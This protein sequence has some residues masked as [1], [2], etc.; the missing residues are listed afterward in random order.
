MA[1]FSKQW[2]DNNDS[3]IEPDFDIVEIWSELPVNFMNSVIC[4]GYGFVAIAKFE[5]YNE[6]IL[7]YNSDIV[8][9]LN[10]FEIVEEP[11]KID[12]DNPF[13]AMIKLS[14]LEKIK[15]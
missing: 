3:Q 1:E 4:E 15:I 12:R 11:E 10:L 9:S 13:I 14:N 6:P 8:N 2:C 7:I 5:E